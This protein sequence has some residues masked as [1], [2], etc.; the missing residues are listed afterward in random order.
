MV[1]RKKI[2]SEILSLVLSGR[3]AEAYTVSQE[4]VGST[5]ASDPMER[6]ATE[7]AAV[8]S[9]RARAKLSTESLIPSYRLA[10]K[11]KRSGLH[12]E[13]KRLF[14]A[15]RLITPK[16]KSDF[17]KNLRQLAGDQQHE[18]LKREVATVRAC[19]PTD[20]F[21]HIAYAIHVL[22]CVPL[23]VE[24]DLL[25]SDLD[26]STQSALYG[27]LVLHN[28]MRSKAEA[29][30][31]GADAGLR[32]LPWA[33]LTKSPKFFEGF[34]EWMSTAG[35]RDRELEKTVRELS[36]GTFLLSDEVRGP[37]S[38]VAQCIQRVDLRHRALYHTSSDHRLDLNSF[39][40]LP[41]PLQARILRALRS[42]RR[43]DRIL[44]LTDRANSSTTL[45]NVLHVVNAMLESGREAEAFQLIGRYQSDYRSEPRY[46]SAAIAVA[47]R[48]DAWSDV[49]RFSVAGLRTAQTED[50]FARTVGELATALRRQRRIAILERVVRHLKWRYDRRK[51]N[52]VHYIGALRS[53]RTRAPLMEL[54]SDV[55]CSHNVALRAS[56]LEGIVE[57]GEYDQAL[58]LSRKWDIPIDSLSDRN[59]GLLQH[60]ALRQKALQVTSF[61]DLRGKILTRLANRALPLEQK[62]TGPTRILILASSLGVGGSERQLT[63]LLTF[64]DQRPQLFSVLL[65]VANRASSS[66]LVNLLNIRILYRDELERSVPYERLAHLIPRFI[67]DDVNLGLRRHNFSSLL[68]LASEFKP[69]VVYNAVGTPVDAILLGILTSA[70]TIVRFGGLSFD[71]SYDASDNQRFLSVLG[72]KLCTL[73]A[74]K[75]TLVA[76][77]HAA[78]RAWTARLGIRG[79]LFKVIP[80]GTGFDAPICLPR[81][82]NEKK[83][84]LFG[85]PDVIVVGFVGR[86]HDVKRPQLWI[87]VALQLADRNPKLRF[88]LVGDGPLRSSIEEKVRAS[89]RRTSFVFTGGV[90]SGIEDLYQSMD[91]LLLTSATESFPNVVIEAAGHGVFVVSSPV[92]DVPLIIN[93]RRQGRIVHE[94]VRSAFVEV[95]EDALQKG[96]DIHRG[97]ARRA[98]EI[99]RRFSVARMWA[100][101]SQ[102]FRRHRTEEANMRRT[103]DPLLRQSF[104]TRV[105]QISTGRREAQ[106]SPRS[107]HGEAKV[108]SLT[109]AKVR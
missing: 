46:W 70:A 1:R 15:S 53:M 81:Q 69:N 61:S 76:N 106:E 95:I 102:L 57:L 50:M 101:Y 10:H 30:P 49:V 58:V 17:V 8:A 42:Q 97:R 39:R 107:G 83:K 85:I 59:R 87:D 88:L 98:I 56:L 22:H 93:D 108:Y 72:E 5:P 19:Y 84:E 105:R 73:F 54:I 23:D 45:D 55:E 75:I 29:S 4:E 109:R 6:V 89:P 90:S 94:D 28:S 62:V 68:K 44:E 12:E 25:A 67:Y 35:L 16:F 11:L 74:D 36:K 71:N 41:A 63:H 14:Q 20:S 80:N 33:A 64:L 51:I 43:F 47:K 77:S 78:E 9:G 7:L 60:F 86:F 91:I 13:S 100:E 18:R 3:A 103:E 24:R 27:Q 26:V 82:R 21:F 40:L 31:S 2:A 79:G 34:C 37:L 66:H 52:L 48:I 38:M 104:A 92:G 96:E 32:L 65:V 99:R